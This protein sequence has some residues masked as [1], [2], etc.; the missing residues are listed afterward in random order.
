LG[1]DE[2]RRGVSRQP[3]GAEYVLRY[4]MKQIGESIYEK[5]IIY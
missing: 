1:G 4:D 2:L 5:G 3:L